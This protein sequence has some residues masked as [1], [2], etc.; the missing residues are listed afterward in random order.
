M[1]GRP[2]PILPAWFRAWLRQKR[3]VTVVVKTLTEQRQK[4]Q[5]L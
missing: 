4:S 3:G 5:K 1:A 2:Y